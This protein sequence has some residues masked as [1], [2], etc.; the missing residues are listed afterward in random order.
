MWNK[1]LMS[2]FF[3]P[4]FFLVLWGISIGAVC[5]YDS[6]Y[7]LQMTEDGQWI[8]ITA[9]VGYLFLIAVLFYVGNDFKDKVTSWG[10]YLFF[11]LVCFLRESGIQHHLS[12]TDSTP[13]KSR[14]FLNP[15]NPISEKIIFGAV[16]ILIFGALCYL[17]IKYTKFLVLSFFKLDTVTWTIAVLCTNGVV[18]KLID[19]FPANYRKAHGGEGLSDSV[20]SI[21][22]L[23]EE[24]SEMFLPYLAMLAL[25]QYHCRCKR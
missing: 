7:V 23:V 13:F 25:Y 11:S 6:A 15:N 18:G 4:V 17:A 2:P 5:F 16:L 10:I 8:D 24:T 19:R 14:F 9:R 20:Y 12:A 1:I 21:F 3:A 22:Q